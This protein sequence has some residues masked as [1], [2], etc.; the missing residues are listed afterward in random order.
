MGFRKVSFI[1]CCID[2]TECFKSGWNST[3]DLVAFQWSYVNNR[4]ASANFPGP[5]FSEVFGSL[6]GWA[7]KW[8]KNKVF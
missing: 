1:R 2:S 7:G 8:K 6:A 5:V 4:I 3:N